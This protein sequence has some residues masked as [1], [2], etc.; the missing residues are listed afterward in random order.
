MLHPNNALC[1]WVVE[2]KHRRLLEEEAREGGGAYAFAE[3]GRLLSMVSSFQYLDRTLMTT[4][5]V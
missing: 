5:Y 3:Y 4:H 2:Q 1:A